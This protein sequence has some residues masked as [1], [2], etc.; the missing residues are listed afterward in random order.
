ME[1]TRRI[2]RYQFNNSKI[3]LFKFWITM[4]AVNILLFIMNKKSGPNVSTGI[5]ISSDISNISIMGVGLFGLLIYFLVYSYENYYQNFPIA[6]SFSVTRKDFV[7]ST[8]FSG[9]IISATSAFIQGLLLKIDPKIVRLVEKRPIYD[10]G[11]FNTS[12]DKV[13]Y[14]IFTLFV[15]FLT[16]LSIWSLLA[17]LNYRFGYRMWILFL[18]LYFI[19]TYI[20]SWYAGI[21][22]FSISIDSLRI[23][24]LQLAQLSLITIISYGLTYLNTINTNIKSNT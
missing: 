22:T 7:L 3:S 10:F 1:N 13:F 8:I 5:I 9:I 20:R 17:S 14:I 18:V 23:G 24:G 15:L 16:L 12:T 2:L 6:I 21:W 4:F 11:I 19:A